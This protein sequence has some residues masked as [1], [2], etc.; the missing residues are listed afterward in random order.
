MTT[1]EIPQKGHPKDYFVH[2]KR[3]S[4]VSQKWGETCPKDPELKGDHLLAP[5]KMDQKWENQKVKRSIRF[6]QLSF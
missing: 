2:I 4:L 5:L 6:G 1:S 3:H